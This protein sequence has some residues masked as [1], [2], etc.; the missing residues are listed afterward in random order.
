[1]TSREKEVVDFLEGLVNK[2]YN[3]ETLGEELSKHFNEEIKPEFVGIDQ[4]DDDGL[5]DWNIMF[6]SE[7]EDTY[8]YFDIYVLMMRREGWDGST[9]MITEIGF[10][11]D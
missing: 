1:M 4:D 7:N 5:T 6:N 3:L 9:F 8:G 11:F 2:R 10:E